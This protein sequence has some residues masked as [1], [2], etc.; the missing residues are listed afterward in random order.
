MRPILSR[1]VSRILDEGLQSVRENLWRPYGT[2]VYFPLYP[3]LRL[4]LRAGLSYAA[5]TALD[6]RPVS[7]AGKSQVW[8]SRRLCGPSAPYHKQSGQRGLTTSAKPYHD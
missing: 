2:R 8:F 4:R 3:A 7:S 1:P 5:P 6:L